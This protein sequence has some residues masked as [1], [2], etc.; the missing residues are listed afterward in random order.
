M[1]P[2]VDPRRGDDLID[3]QGGVRLGSRRQRVFRQETRISVLIMTRRD[4]GDA[5]EDVPD[6][7]GQHAPGRAGQQPA[8]TT[9]HTESLEI[10]HQGL[11]SANPTKSIDRT[12][13][14]LCQ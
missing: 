5:A 13:V 7:A 8:G 14:V 1:V 2:D 9:I 3:G 6:D 11:K 12:I 10:T 4:D